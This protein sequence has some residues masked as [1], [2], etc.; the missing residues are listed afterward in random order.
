MRETWVWS[1]GRED[2]LEKEMA[3]HSSTPAWK[4]P[5]TEETGRLQSKGS[6]RVGHDW[7]T[8]L[9]F[10]FN[11]VTNFDIL[12]WMLVKLT[13]IF[14]IIITVDTCSVQV[15]SH[16]FLFKCVLHSH[17]SCGWLNL[18]VWNRRYC[19]QSR[20]QSFSTKSGFQ[21]RKQLKVK[22]VHKTLPHFSCF[23]DFLPTVPPSGQA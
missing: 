1:L 2:P 17:A 12:A 5:W 10:T 19:I 18:L 11:I 3:T 4:I 6:Q 15:H 13:E 20:R 23:L 8:S 14:I 9:T 22:D 16:R 7:E 21:F